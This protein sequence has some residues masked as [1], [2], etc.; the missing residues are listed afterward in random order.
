MVT[1]GNLYSYL[2]LAAIISEILNVTLCMEI[3]YKYGLD[4][5]GSTFQWFNSRQGLGIFLFTTA[6]SPALGPTQPVIQWVWG[7]YP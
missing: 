5:R 4:D 1:E 6:S 3:N 7:I 2:P